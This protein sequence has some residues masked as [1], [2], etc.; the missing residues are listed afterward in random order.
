MT[1]G[2]LAGARVDP[3]VLA[4]R[5]DYV[6]LLLTA[7]GVRGG[8]C[9]AGTEGVL[10]T[11]EARARE[12]LAAVPLDQV[13]HVVQW[14]EAF[15]AFD[16]KPQKTRPSV[17]ALLR[18]VGTGLPRVDRLT[19]VYNAVSI[20]HVVPVGGEDLDT[21][22]GPP[23]LVRCDGTE[24]FDTTAGGAPVVEHPAAGEV[25]WRDDLGVTCRRWNWRQCTRTRITPSTTAAG[26]VLDGLGALGVDGLTAAADDLEA[27]L[28]A[29]NPG[30]TFARR[31]LPDL[32][33]S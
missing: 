12:A 13:P 17:E 7:H 9:D 20:A 31:L 5:P 6:A 23:R 16:A 28:L 29:T 30:A 11:A 19:D 21:Y 25:V 15:R 14:R 22:A 2:W 33:S 32:Q 4:V 26:F 3:Q 18:R 1:A 8:P 27:A 10:A 24:P